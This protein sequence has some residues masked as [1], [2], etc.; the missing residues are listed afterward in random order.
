MLKR[1]ENR[2]MKM[3][4]GSIEDL[5]PKE[6]FLRDL[7]KLIDFLFIYEKVES[8]YSNTG[9]PSV[10]PILLVKMLLIG[11]LYRIDSERKLEQEI[12]INIAYRWFLGIDTIETTVKFGKKEVM[13]KCPINLV[14]TRN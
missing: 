13:K 8:L 1:N 5:M 11:Y 7:D 3:F 10:D 14:L 6:H 9:R 12:K 4:M 2:Q